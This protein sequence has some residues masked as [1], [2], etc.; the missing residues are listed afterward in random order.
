MTNDLYKCGFLHLPFLNSEVDCSTL[1]G[2]DNKT[3]KTLKKDCGWPIIGQLLHTIATDTDVQQKINSCNSTANNTATAAANSTAT[4]NTATAT[5]NSTAPSNTAT[6]AASTAPSNVVSNALSDASGNCILNTSFSNGGGACQP[7][8]SCVTGQY[9]HQGPSLS[10]DRVCRNHSP[11][12]SSTQFE[13]Q[14]ATATQDRI[15]QNLTPSCSANQFESQSPS[16]TQNRICQT[17]TPP[18]S[19]NEYES[20]SPGLT[21]DRICSPLTQCTSQQFEVTPPTSTTDRQCQNLTECTEAQFE[22]LAPTATSNRQCTNL[23][24]CDDVV[25]NPTNP[26]QFESIPPTATTNR[27]CAQLSPPCDDVTHPDNIGNARNATEYESPAAGVAND[28]GCLPLTTCNWNDNNINQSTEYESIAP[29]KYTNR[30][31]APL[32]NCQNDMTD[33]SDTNPNA[34][35]FE[36]RAPQY[37]INRECSPLTV[38]NTTD[39]NT[40]SPSQIPN[41]LPTQRVSTTRT[42]TTDRV[43]SNLT[44]C[45]STEYQSTTP[46]HTTDR[47]CSVITDCERCSPTFTGCTDCAY[48]VRP[49]NPNANPPVSRGDPVRLCESENISCDFDSDEI[50]QNLKQMYVQDVTCT[51]KPIASHL[52]MQWTRNENDVCVI[53]CG[54]G[55]HY[56]R[57]SC[58]V[59]GQD[60]C[61]DYTTDA[62]FIKERPRNRNSEWNF[63]FTNWTIVGER[64]PAN[65]CDGS[66]PANTLDI[67]GFC[68]HNDWSIT[69]D[70]VANNTRRSMSCEATNVS[71][72]SELKRKNK[73][74]TVPAYFNNLE[75]SETMLQRTASNCTSNGRDSS[76]FS[77]CTPT[78]HYTST[79]GAKWEYVGTTKP[80]NTTVLTGGVNPLI[81]NLPR[82]GSTIHEFHFCELVNATN[83]GPDFSEYC[84]PSNLQQLP[85]FVESPV[86]NLPI[87]ID[88]NNNTIN[89]KD[90]NSSH[91]IQTPNGE[92]YRHVKTVQE[93]MI[94]IVNSKLSTEN[95]SLPPLNIAEPAIPYQACNHLN[96]NECLDFARA[97]NIHHTGTQAGDDR[98]K[99]RGCLMRSQG[100]RYQPYIEYINASVHNPNQSID[101]INE[102]TNQDDVSCIC[103]V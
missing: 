4:N 64:R 88:E 66:S 80:N 50:L 28:R 61:S 73:F 60:D 91:V 69:Q 49:A 99:E 52:N 87:F 95:I 23:T 92:Y 42:A 56:F 33:P 55:S 77:N 5:A 18:C 26:T 53:G 40:T 84:A 65:E 101:H 100:Y 6:A 46:T 15:C 1:R 29:T 63:P 82:N 68:R 45:P 41:P 54:E 43:C 47:E 94:D 20:Q 103:R 89:I 32:R 57:G 67:N 36:S 48:Q 70:T 58:R 72:P 7:V 85:G 22:S 30:T 12:C 98:Q 14:P 21:Q 97:Y 86:T 75:F 90:I 38:C 13:I 9:E 59:L 34:T 81:N 35:E 71:N 24:V 51:Q 96:E 39:V 10:T 11:T 76:Q 44:I 83:L 78:T 17:L 8:T 3:R 27:Q 19:S 93:G 31:C 37:N 102:C 16:P 62:S 2:M 74:E 79:P 25:R